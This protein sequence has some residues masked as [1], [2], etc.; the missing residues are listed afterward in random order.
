MNPF[1]Q[2]TKD[3]AERHNA[4]VAKK[5]RND[6]PERAEPPEQKPDVRDGSNGSLEIQKARSLALYE[7]AKRLWSLTG[8]SP[9]VLPGDKE[10][11]RYFVLIVDQRLKEI[12]E[13][14]LEAKYFLDM[15]RYSKK[16]EDDCPG[17]CKSY[18]TQRLVQDEAD[19]GTLIEITEL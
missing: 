3:D 7:V 9:V 16:I 13:D 10:K 2:W 15:L 17:A 12:D 18:T 14:N 1:S 6:I 4:R 5:V 8:T 19:V 11:K